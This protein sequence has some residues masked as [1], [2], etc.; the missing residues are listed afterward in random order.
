MNFLKNYINADNTAEINPALLWD[1]GQ[2]KIDYKKHKRIIVQR[3]VEYGG[4][5]DWAKMFSL[6][7]ENEIIAEIKELVGLSALNANFVCKLFNLKKT[8]LKCYTKTHWR[9]AHWS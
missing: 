8:D 9:I 4:P 6:Y 3:V 1:F 5:E 7:S 2:K